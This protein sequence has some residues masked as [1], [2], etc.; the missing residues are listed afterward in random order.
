MAVKVVVKS[1]SRYL[2][3]RSGAFRPIEN[4]SI[5]ANLFLGREPTWGGPLRFLQRAP[6]EQ[7]ARK[8]LERLGLDSPPGGPTV[9]TVE[10]PRH[11]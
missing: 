11:A 7:A 6:M 1:D 2:Q 5:T 10:L 3:E 8:W 9:V 4:L